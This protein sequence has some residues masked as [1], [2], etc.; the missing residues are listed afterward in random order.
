MDKKELH[1][2]IN[3]LFRKFWSLD[4]S[5]DEE[6]SKW[7]K[8]WEELTDVLKTWAE[9]WSKTD[10]SK[11]ANTSDEKRDLP[12]VEEGERIELKSK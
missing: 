8:Q 9:D 6:T 10:T 3:A 1:D 11:K 2:S 7:F 4:Y 12:V 5:N